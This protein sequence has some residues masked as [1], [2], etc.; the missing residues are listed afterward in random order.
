LKIYL[1]FPNGAATHNDGRAEQ[2]GG[3]LPH[4]QEGLLRREP[5][6]VA[7]H[8]HDRAQQ[9]Q[10]IGADRF[11]SRSSDGGQIVSAF[12]SFNLPLVKKYLLCFNFNKS[13]K[14]FKS[15]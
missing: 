11:Q 8:D 6:P 7:G 5:D 3:C 4:H 14:I 15:N 10:T 2:Q 12:S 13:D 1:A 9:G